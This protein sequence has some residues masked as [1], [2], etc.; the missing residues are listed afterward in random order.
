MSAAALQGASRE[1]LAASRETV[2][3][4]VRTP[5]TDPSRLA[6]DLFGLTALLDQERALRRAMTDP[7]R[8]SDD[9]AGL[10]RAVAGSEVG[11]AALDVFV[12]AARARWSGPRDLAD[13]LEILSVDAQVAAADRAGRLDA[14]EDELFRVGRIVAGNAELR[15]ALSDRSAPVE[16][17]AALLEGLLGDQVAPETAVLLRQAVIAPRGRTFDR[18]V[19]L[20]GRIAAEQRSRLVATVTAAVPLT[21]E[22]RTRL[23]NALRRI[24]GA[25]VH[26]NIQVAPDIVGGIS[27]EIGDEVIDGSVMSRLED[28]RRRLAG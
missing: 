28:A 19:E 1:S 23:G 20:F 24:Y 11:P 12:W 15:I 21:T 27:V 18:S 5:D 26:L 9:R 6:G 16:A 8:S 7:S 3:T 17:R 10:A 4:L 2:A 25:E 13:A 22:Q 14:V